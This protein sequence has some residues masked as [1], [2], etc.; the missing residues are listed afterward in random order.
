MPLNFIS[1]GPS[2]VSSI[3][4]DCLRVTQT[5][6]NNLSPL[7][8]PYTCVQPSSNLG[9]MESLLRFSVS[10]IFKISLLNFWL[11]CLCLAFP[12]QD[13]N[14]RV[15]ESLVFPISLLPTLVLFLTTLL[16]IGFLHCAPNKVSSS[17]YFW[18]SGLVPPL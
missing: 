16:G 2:H 11:V 15:A 5:C 13:C 9:C 7:S 17:E 18:F 8:L 10:L 3:C 6:V 1:V 14:P 12:S 4:V